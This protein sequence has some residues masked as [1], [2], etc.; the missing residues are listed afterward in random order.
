[1]TFV[2]SEQAQLVFLTKMQRIFEEGRFT[3]T[4]K[5]ALVTA[6]ADLCVEIDA[7]GDGSLTLPIAAIADK[8]I[9]L[10]WDQVAPFGSGRLDQS[11][12]HPGAVIAGIAEFRRETAIASAGVARAD[13][14]YGR[15]RATVAANLVAQPIAYLQNVAGQADRFLFAPPRGGMLRLEPGVAH[16]MR[17][18]HG[19]VTQ[20][21]RAGWVAKVKA[22]PANQQLLGD[23]EDV[24]D[25]LFPRSRM[26]LVAFGNAL[27]D[28]DGS[29]CFYC[30][31]AVDVADVDHFIPIS[32]YRRDLAHNLVR[33][34]ATC[35]RSKSDILAGFAHLEKWRARLSRE[36]VAIGELGARY[37]VAAEPHTALSVARW[38]YES[39]RVAGAAAWLRAKSFEP[40]DARFM[41]LLQEGR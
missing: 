5:Y 11:A 14:E 34:H 12:G 6:L 39:G 35:N 9:D 10:Y 16:C 28:I 23:R 4:Y 22:I 36:A 19:I 37:G 41:T 1:M 13:A 40:I 26:A 33:A 18:F 2:P 20:L 8:V 31:R 15:L 21:A 30:G 29:G 17:R 7:A 38:A 3:S 24:E 25:F 32:R 27:R